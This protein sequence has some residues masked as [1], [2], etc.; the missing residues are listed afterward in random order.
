[1]K[2]I[3]L[4]ASVAVLAGCTTVGPDYAGPPEMALNDAAWTQQSGEGLQPGYQDISRWWTVLDDPVLNALIEQAAA[5]TPNLRA[6]LSRIDQA[7]AVYGIAA[8]ERYPAIDAAGS[9]SRSESSEAETGLPSQT[10]NFSNIGTAL[11][12]ELDL[13]GR[14]RRQTEAAEAE[15]EASVEDYRAVLVVLNAEIARTYVEARTL[16]K[17]LNLIA[18]NIEIQKKT[19]ELV[20]SR[21]KA[22][23]V[24]EVD[25][26][27]ARQ[28][29]ASS[30]SAQPLLRA[31]LGRALNRL[32]VLIGKQPGA[33]HPQLM[34]QE[35]IPRVPGEIVVAI[36]RDVMRQ[37][38]DIRRAE[39]RLAAQT[40]RIGVAEADLY[41][42]LNLA[43]VFAFATG[44]GGGGLL[45]SEAQKWAFGSNLTWNVLDGGRTR[46]RIGLEDARAEEARANYEQTVLGAFEDVENSLINFEEESKRLVYLRQSVEAAQ[47]TVEKAEI[48]YKADLTSFQTV[49][50]AQR[51]L[52]AGED[53]LANS[54]GALV[55]YLVSI[56]RAMGGGWENAPQSGT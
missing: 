29:L 13:F 21:Y 19:L 37:R 56:Y 11:S 20:E 36:P 42:R 14:I 30:Q 7:G 12:W 6:A 24:S 53:N 17:R 25:V 44:L 45:A 55:G 18:R 41:P 9:A 49:L 48:Q 50:D 22:E 52:L 27:Q 8:S 4:L 2:K 51:V 5:G 39:R 33:L 15:V 16:Q 54:E 1:M 47:K 34:I 31:A 3:L 35:P 40:A 26:L 46:N 10:E 38:P 32:A 23:L 28:N 43:G